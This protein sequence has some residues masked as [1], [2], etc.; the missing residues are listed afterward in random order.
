MLIFIKNSLEC[1][2]FDTYVIIC[3]TWRQKQ[4]IWEI[5][6]L[7]YNQMAGILVCLH[8]FLQTMEV[9]KVCSSF[10]CNLNSSFML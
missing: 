8:A 1:S 5:Q 4:A 2:W 7:T 6:Q 9:L 3:S 10:R